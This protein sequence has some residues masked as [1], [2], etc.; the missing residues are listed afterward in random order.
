MED[1][2]DE[3]T[4]ALIE[5]YKKVKVAIEKE[6]IVIE[7]NRAGEDIASTITSLATG[8]S[9]LKELTKS[10][11]DLTIA[12]TKLGTDGKLTAKDW[13]A[14]VVQLN[15]ALSST[16]DTMANGLDDSQENGK[17]ALKTLSSLLESF[18]DIKTII[19]GIIVLL[20]GGG[21]IIT[22][23]IG[24]AIIK[25]KEKTKKALEEVDNAISELQESMKD[26]LTDTQTEYLQKALTAWENYAKDVIRINSGIDGFLD[27]QREFQLEKEKRQRDAE[28]D[29]LKDVLSS[30][31][32]EN[33]KSLA[34]KRI[35]EIDN[36]QK[37]LLAQEQIKREEEEL[38]RK[39][40]LARLALKVAQFQS[41]ME[42]KKS[43]MEVSQAEAIAGTYNIRKKGV[44]EAAQL[45]INNAYAQANSIL[46]K[47]AGIGAAGFEL[48]RQALTGELT[49]EDIQGIGSAVDTTTAALDRP[50]VITLDGK[51]IAAVT[52]DYSNRNLLTG[53][54][55]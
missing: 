3:V 31:V 39:L 9:A 50:I 2:S 47:A 16:F 1:T 45:Q 52:E 26:F 53:S 21:D 28:I 35:D 38:E 27:K 15:S 43:S 12:F 18:T 10:L 24:G 48:E 23:L 34:Q 20:A 4:N 49:P 36:E 44:R 25:F 11:T 51:Q 8:D 17:V 13:I 40:Q 54:A 6:P 42:L 29:L 5:D 14:L 46:Q 33:E 55:Q 30:E 19:F 7:Y 37:I 41:E 22:T 32:S